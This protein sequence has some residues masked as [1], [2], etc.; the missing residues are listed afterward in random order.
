M[1]E[2]P[3]V[4]TVSELR[5]AIAAWR[6]DGLTLALVPTMGAL[7]EGHLALVRRGLER[8]ERVCVTLFVNP[9]QFAPHE[10]F[11]CYPRDEA[12]DAAKLA[13]AGAHL[14]F[15]PDAAEMYPAGEVTR[16]TV[17][18][19]GEVL[20]GQFRPQFFTGV[21][22]VVTKLLL[23]ALPDVAIFGEKDYQQ[24]RVIRRMVT[25]LFIPVAIDG[26]PTVREADGLALS[27][28]NAYLSP[29]ERAIAPRLQQALQAF[30]GQIRADAAAAKRAADVE[31]LLRDAGFSKVDYVRVCEAATLQPWP[32][33]PAAGRIL[34]AAWLGR[35]RLIDNIPL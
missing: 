9:T 7:H 22:T 8:A 26:A 19:L 24:L 12:G 34:A 5:A 30:A 16:V 1:P 20:E 17:P 18:S 6:A 25:D 4:R 11:D 33:P 32:G 3:V 13:N 14:L 2:L 31:Q 21:A 10:D 27:S 28:R 15:V 23:Q 29:A 35:T